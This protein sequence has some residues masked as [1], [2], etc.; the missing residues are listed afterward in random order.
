MI[1]LVINKLDPHFAVI[2]FCY[3]SYDYRPN[4][5]PLSP[6]TIINCT[7]ETSESP[8]EVSS[9]LREFSEMFGNVCLAFRKLLEN[10]RKASERGLKSSESRQKHSHVCIMISLYSKKNYMVA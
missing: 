4:W 2:R 9:N 8:S 10:L 6:I 7:I 5:T 1:I 3:H